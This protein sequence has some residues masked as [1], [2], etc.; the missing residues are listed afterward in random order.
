MKKFI[1]ILLLFPVITLGQQVQTL[2]LAKAYELA[3]QNYPLIKQR[4]LLKQT[5]GI[6]IDNLN[7]GFFP[8]FSLSGEAYLS[9]AG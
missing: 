5:T 7:R 2:S 4:D 6:T 1:V 8:Q 9:I 3:Q